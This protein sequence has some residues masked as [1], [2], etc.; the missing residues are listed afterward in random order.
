MQSLALHEV[1]AALHARFGELAGME[2]VADYGQP[3]A[4]YAALHSTAV[5]VDLSFRGRLCLTGA[6]RVRLLNGQVTNDVKALKVGQ[7]CAAAFCSPKGRLVAD[8]HIFALA[9]ELLLEFEPGLSAAL[10]QRLEHHIV[11]EDVQVVDVAPHYG[12]L[13]VQGP[14]SA[15]VVSQ[16]ELFE[17]VPETSLSTKAASDPTLG[18]LYLVNRSRAAFPGFDLFVP[19]DSV[20]AVFDKLVSA[21]RNVGGCAAGFEALDLARF[22]AGLPRFPVDMD[23]TNLPP[24]TGLERSGISYTK[25]C[26]TGQ[27]TIARLRTYG[28]V[29]KA[30]RGLRLPD[31]LVPLPSKGAKLKHDRREVGYVTSA[32]FSPAL[33]ANLALGYVRKGSN[34][35][36]TELHLQSGTS[37]VP[38]RVVELPFP[39]FHGLT[40]VATP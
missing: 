1:H 6:D 4:E 38:V 20:S 8:V 40:S 37:E 32:R 31:G 21:T 18:E 12:L 7:G 26:Y 36:G 11:A 27:E 5:S 2:L 28:Q 14:R 25:G 9:E 24:E 34:A 3:E 29:V 22:E 17:A 35:V 30:L 19:A 13:T 23:E 10:I 15:D 39:D 16:L 33:G